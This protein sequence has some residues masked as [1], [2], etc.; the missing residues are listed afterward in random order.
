M[1]LAWVQQWMSLVD[2]LLVY[3]IA[4]VGIGSIALFNAVMLS[5][6]MFT[7]DIFHVSGWGVVPSMGPRLC[8]SM[9]CA[10]NRTRFRP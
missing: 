10:E 7:L 6:A 4:N 8:G 5:V 3:Q 9:T 2:F 1:F